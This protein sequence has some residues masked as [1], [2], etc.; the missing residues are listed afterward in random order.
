[1]KNITVISVVILLPLLSMIS[2][3]SA[4]QE[5]LDSIVWQAKTSGYWKANEKDGYYRV[6]VNREFGKE[7]SFDDVTVQILE[8]TKINKLKILKTVSLKTPGYKGY[9]R[10]ISLKRLDDTRAAVSVDIEMKA[11]GGIVLRE[12]HIVTINGKVNKVVDAVSKDLTGS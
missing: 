3:A 4:K 1:M 9:V 12:V 6:L 5:I 8:L 2:L 11:M 10:D 7:H